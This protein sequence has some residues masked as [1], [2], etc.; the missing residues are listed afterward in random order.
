MCRPA[1]C[2]APC[3]LFAPLFVQAEPALQATATLAS[4]HLVRGVSR[5]NDQPAVSALLHVQGRTGWFGSL[6]ASSS[7]D[8]A[9]DGT[10]ADLAATVGFAASLRGDWSMRASVSHYDSP[11]QRYADFYRYD[12][13]TVDLSFRQSLLL[14]A[15]YSPNTSRYSSAYGAAWRREA[16]AV[17]ATWQQGI[18][19]NLGVFAGVG[20]YDLSD[21]FGQGYV[22]GSAGIAWTWRQ[23]QFDAAWVVTGEA[24]RRLSYPGDAGNKA[25]VS[26]TWAFRR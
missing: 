14:S 7:H 2:I 20:Y 18:T 26:A 23:W 1:G 24:A 22:Y 15:S 10:T 17:E 12:E 3:L 5:S 25:L 13:L 19:G 11:W 6:W 8:R 16:W 4:N 9:E 21:L